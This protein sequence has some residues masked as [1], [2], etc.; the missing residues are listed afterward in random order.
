[1]RHPHESTCQIRS[2]AIHS[3]D[4]RGT[5]FPAPRVPAPPTPA[6]VSGPATIFPPT[7]RS[8]CSRLGG[9]SLR[10]LWSAFGR[11]RASRV[12]VMPGAYPTEKPPLLPEKGALGSLCHVLCGPH[13]PCLRSQRAAAVQAPGI[14]RSGIRT[15]SHPGCGCPMPDV[16]TPRSPSRPEPSPGPPLFE[17]NG[18]TLSRPRGPAGHIQCPLPRPARGVLFPLARVILSGG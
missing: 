17:S 6:G 13:A 10:S 1:M 8:P 12:N 2:P 18:L 14:L 5:L 7:A 9:T 4:R 3:P 16:V 11:T 15:D